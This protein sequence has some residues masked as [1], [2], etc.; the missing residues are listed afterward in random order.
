MGMCIIINFQQNTTKKIFSNM[1]YIMRFIYVGILALA[2]YDQYEDFFLCKFIFKN[3][4]Q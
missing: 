4:L 1:L 2:A 3:S